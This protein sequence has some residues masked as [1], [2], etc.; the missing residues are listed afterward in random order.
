[1]S[2]ENND[3]ISL[4]A[5]LIAQDIESIES[6]PLTHFSVDDFAIEKQLSMM[7]SRLKSLISH[8]IP[9]RSTADKSTNIAAIFKVLVTL[10]SSYN[11]TLW[12]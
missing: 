10:H 2:E 7:P 6:N 12:E 4:A 8:L 1:M 5:N 11:V 3:I 9:N